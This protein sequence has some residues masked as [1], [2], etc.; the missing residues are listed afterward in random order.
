MKIDNQWITANV[1]VAVVEGKLHMVRATSRVQVRLF[2]ARKYVTGIR[3]ATHD[4]LLE[5]VRGGE[6]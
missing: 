2:L 1:Y 5:N 4:E 6:S 3:I